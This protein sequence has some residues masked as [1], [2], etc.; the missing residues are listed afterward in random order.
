M[1]PKAVS[2]PHKH[3]E[4]KEHKMKK[5][6]KIVI[7][8]ILL[9]QWASTMAK[10]DY[11]HRLEYYGIKDHSIQKAVLIL[12]GAKHSSIHYRIEGKPDQ[13]GFP[14]KIFYFEFMFKG[15]FYQFSFHKPY[16]KEKPCGDKNIAW[17]GEKGG[18]IERYIH[19][20][21]L[22]GFRNETFR[23]EKDSRIN[24]LMREFL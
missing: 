23:G 16:G 6:E 7:R 9:A 13:N 1:W 12:N 15:E 20:K 3:R 18:C 17:D 19:L 14:S 10:N 8:H 21:P 22:I 2:S 24:Q 4:R 11:C 5:I